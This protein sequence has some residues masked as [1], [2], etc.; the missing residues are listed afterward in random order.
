MPLQCRTLRLAGSAVD[1]SQ[2][3]SLERPCRLCKSGLGLAGSAVDR[4]QFMS[5]ER[6]CRLCKSGPEHQSA[7][8]QYWRILS[9]ID[10]A[11]CSEDH[12]EVM[13]LNAGA[14][15]KSVFSDG[16]LTEAVWLTHRLLWALPWAA[17]HVPPSA[18][19]AHA[20]G[21]IFDSTVL[22][23]H[24]VRA[25]ADAW[26]GWSESVKWTR[27]FG[28]E[29]ARQLPTGKAASSSQA[30]DAPDSELEPLA[31]AKQHHVH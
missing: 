9:Q 5:L 7:V 4:S 22:S 18:V 11:V 2:F 1:R 29:W 10:A 20:L 14:A 8:L 13:G 6:P 12:V 25:M 16:S 23:R 24:A 27:R 28:D 19:A 31:P 21:Q 17:R 15:L 26:V 30:A 3:M